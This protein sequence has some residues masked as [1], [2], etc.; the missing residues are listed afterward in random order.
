MTSGIYAIV[1]TATGKGY[2]GSAVNLAKRWTRHKYLL[3]H[4][5]H[6]NGHL[7][8]A[9]IKYGERAF[10]FEI[11]KRCPL[12]DLIAQE[13]EW[14]DYYWS[15]N[16]LYGYN[17]SPIAGSPMLGRKHS[18]ETRAKMHARKA[19]LETRAKMSAAARGKKLLPEH[20]A[21][22]GLALRG[23]KVS[24]ETRAKISQA[25]RGR[26]RGIAARN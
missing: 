13:Q 24:A 6:D 7:Q 2:V 3:R 25:K 1:N 9:W 26:Y 11:I 4:G 20:R 21:K 17:L 15:N 8:A 10:A 5:I 22:I 19:S 18:V 12:L 16:G 14:I 23:H